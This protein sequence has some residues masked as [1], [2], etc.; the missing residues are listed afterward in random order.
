VPLNRGAA[1]AGQ[2][3]RFFDHGIRPEYTGF[4]AIE[5]APLE[6]TLHSRGD[7]HEQDADLFIGRRREGSETKRVTL[8]FAE[9]DAVEEQRVEMDVQIQSAAK[10][11]DDGHRPGPP[12]PDPVSA[13]A[14][15][16]EPQ[17]HPYGHAQH[18]ARQRMIPRQEMAKTVLFCGP[19]TRS[20]KLSLRKA[21]ENAVS[22]TKLDDVNFHT[23]RHTFASW[24]SCAA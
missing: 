2:G 8:A 6:Q 12:V 1:D 21:Y 14:V 17:Q 15:P 5:T 3:G 4:A 20:G 9:E 7:P 22:N 19:R 11:L 16:L 13:R 24:R 23:L 10:A 18:G